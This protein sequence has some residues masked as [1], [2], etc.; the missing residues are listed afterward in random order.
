M[1][2]KYFEP[3]PAQPFNRARMVSPAPNKI[4]PPAVWPRHKIT[5]QMF[6]IGPGA[7]R[8]WQHREK[9]A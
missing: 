2:A 6:V 9:S 4:E 8:P 3:T 7:T 5:K 1:G